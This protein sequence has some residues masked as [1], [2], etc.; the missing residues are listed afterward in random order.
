MIKVFISYSHDSDEHRE[1][2]LGLSERLRAN[3]IETILDRYVRNGSPPEGWP[4]WM[5]NSLDETTY[6]LCVCTETYYR[7][8]H[9]H[10]VPDKGKGVDWEGTAR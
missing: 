5:S 10:E 4:R 1:W 9:G 7:R 6:V 8:F 3:G 2:V